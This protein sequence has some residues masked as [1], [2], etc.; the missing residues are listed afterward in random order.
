MPTTMAEERR[1]ESAR[2]R[3]LTRSVLEMV[4]TAETCITGAGG[5]EIHSD[6][7]SRGGWGTRM[8]RNSKTGEVDYSQQDEE[9]ERVMARL[10]YRKLSQ[11]VAEPGDVAYVVIVNT[12]SERAP[13]YH[14]P[15]MVTEVRGWSLHPRG[16]GG[17][18]SLRL[19]P[20]H[21]ADLSPRERYI[22]EDL[23]EELGRLTGDSEEPNEEPRETFEE[24]MAEEEYDSFEEDARKLTY[25]EKLAQWE[26]QQR[27]LVEQ[28]SGGGQYMPDDEWRYL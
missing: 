1:E 6:R 20:S 17:F 7:L 19:T 13:E 5:I 18:S 9:S 4:E 25:E 14:V 22:R 12:T 2:R 15:K 23:D 21:L 27:R 10:L 28:E 26:E 16:D 3:A 8:Q 11:A 24:F